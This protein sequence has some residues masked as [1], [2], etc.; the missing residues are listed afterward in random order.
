MPDVADKK[1]KSNYYAQSFYKKKSANKKHQHHEIAK[2]R[3]L[4]LRPT[5]V[6]FCWLDTLL[7]LQNIKEVLKC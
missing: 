7:I 6:F 5:A 1:R 4:S 3:R 2:V